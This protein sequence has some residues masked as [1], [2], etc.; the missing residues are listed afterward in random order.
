MLGV[1]RSRPAVLA[2]VSGLSL[3]LGVSVLLQQFAVWALTVGTLVVLPLAMS[4]L[5]V[6]AVRRLDRRTQES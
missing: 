4:A 1:I 3:G 2:G 5:A 6:L